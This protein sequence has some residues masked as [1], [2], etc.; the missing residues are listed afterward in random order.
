MEI[1]FKVVVCGTPL[2]QAGGKGVITNASGQNGF[3]SLGCIVKRTATQSKH[4]LSCW[5]VLKGDF[6]YSSVDSFTTIIDR[7]D[8]SHLAERWAG[9]IR[10]QF[11]YGF[12]RCTDQ[13]AYQDN[14]FLIEKLNVGKL[15]HRVVSQADIDN[16]IDIKFYNALSNKITKGFI[17]TDTAAIDINYIDKTRVVTDV[18]ILTSEEETTISQEGNSGA[19]VFDKNNVAIGMIIGGDLKYTYAVKLSHV[20]KLHQEMEMA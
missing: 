10:A 18:L 12:A 3:G 20:F 19:L 4:I 6:D 14:S 11:D 1:P 2:S 5:H 17:Y 15:K 9:G 16:Q 8:D 7:H 13:C